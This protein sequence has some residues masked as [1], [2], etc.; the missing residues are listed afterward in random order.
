[1]AVKDQARPQWRKIKS[2]DPKRLAKLIEA[3]FELVSL[4]KLYTREADEV[5]AELRQ[6]KAL[7]IHDFEKSAINE[8]ATKLG[9]ARFATKDVPV[10]DPGS[11]GWEATYAYIVQ[12][13]IEKFST[14]DGK[15]KL[16]TELKKY[17]K[18]LSHY[19]AQHG[20]WDI[21]HKR[22]GEKAC[23]ARWEEKQKIPGVKQFTQAD[24]KFGDAE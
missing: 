19:I 21:L 11:G 24:I 1:M 6:I 12:D 14:A 3:G 5:D 15:L 4:K 2:D 18:R 17:H 8:I 7:V 9:T 23:A 22:L 10:S 16:D 13:A 20:F